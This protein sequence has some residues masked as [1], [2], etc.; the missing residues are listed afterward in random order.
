MSAASDTYKAYQTGR[1]KRNETRKACADMCCLVAEGKDKIQ[2]MIGRTERLV[3]RK[4]RR[5]LLLDI[6]MARVNVSNEWTASN[7]PL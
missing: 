3:L 5:A 7:E 4:Q 1:E 2:E 6:A